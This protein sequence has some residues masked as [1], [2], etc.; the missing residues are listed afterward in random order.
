VGYIYLY[1]YGQNKTRPWFKSQSRRCRAT[2]LGKLFTPIVPLFT[3]QQNWYSS[4]LKGREDNCRP[5]GRYRR[6]YDSRHLQADCQE[7]RD[8]LRNPTLGNRVPATFA[9]FCRCKSDAGHHCAPACTRGAVTCIVNRINSSSFTVDKQSNL[10]QG[11]RTGTESW[12]APTPIY[13]DDATHAFY[14]EVSFINRPTC[15]VQ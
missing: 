9:F 11:K 4:P 2:V 8:Q 7:P 6:V 14:A 1:L 12:P 13:H 10:P 3:K 15:S 5:G